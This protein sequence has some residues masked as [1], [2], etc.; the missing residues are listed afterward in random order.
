MTLR[1]TVDPKV[2]MAK[3]LFPKIPKGY[4]AVQSD[5]DQPLQFIR[6]SFPNFGVYKGWQKIQ[7]Q[8]GDRLET[9]VIISPQGEAQVFRLATLD[10]GMLI[11]ADPVRAA[12]RYARE[13]GN[14]CRCNATLTDERSRYYGIGPECEKSWP[15]VIERVDESVELQG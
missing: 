3:A 14:C 13:I 15:D 11:V 7:S 1:S 9:G 6:V 2:E 8:H 10:A 4:Y 12:I 5:G